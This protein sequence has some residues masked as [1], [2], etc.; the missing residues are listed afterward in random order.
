M[1]AEAP[2]PVQ[3]PLDDPERLRSLQPVHVDEAEML[4]AHR[5]R[6]AVAASKVAKQFDEIDEYQKHVLSMI[7]DGSLPDWNSEVTALGSSI[8]REPFIRMYCEQM[9]Q[10]VPEKRRHFTTIEMMLKAINYVV[11]TAPIYRD[12]NSI[13]WQFPF[14]SLMN[15]WMMTPAGKALLR[16]PQINDH[17]NRVMKSWC[18]F[19]NSPAS[20][21]VLNDGPEGWLNPAAIEY[22]KLDTDYLIPDRSAPHWGFTCYNEFFHRDI[23]PGAR[24]VAGPGDPSVVNSPNDGVCWALQEDVKAYDAFWLKSQRYSLMDMLDYSP[25]TERFIGGAVYQT[26]VNGGADWHRFTAPIDGTVVEARLVPGYAWTESDAVAVDPESGPYSQGWAA[27]VATRA[28]IF[29]DSGLP[30]LGT[31]CVVPIGLTEV[32]SVELFVK[33]GDTVKKGDQL[34]WFSFGGS[35]FALVFQPGAI[36]RFLVKPPRTHRNDQ[37]VDTLKANGQFAVANAS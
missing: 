26:F 37:P 12:V 21:Y 35:S 13:A 25:F 36:S 34:G 20:L 24:P 27:G 9:L 19:L 32:S 29:I 23:L 8:E 2:H 7:T 22:N 31:V 14:S 4:R 18:T 33:E 1:S 30:K 15:F 16:M 10:Q 5:G 3:V 17:I 28:L 6:L 11:H